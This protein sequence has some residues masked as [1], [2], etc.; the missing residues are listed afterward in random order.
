MQL[1]LDGSNVIKADRQTVFGRLTSPEF[2]AK[3]LPDAED[4]KVVGTDQVEAKMKV[5]IAVVTSTLAV[6]MTIAEKTPPSKAKLIAVASGSGSAMTI[7]SVFELSD[8]TPTTMSWSA[9]AEITGV[10]AGLGSTLLRGF[11]T[12][13]VGEIFAGITKAIEG[14]GA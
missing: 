10:M 7:N 8:G 13:K 1:H 6:K 11:A 9:D 4:V 2:L 3:S 12:K 14:A 5:R